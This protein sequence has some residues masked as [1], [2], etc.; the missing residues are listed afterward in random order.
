MPPTYPIYSDEFRQQAVDLLVSS[1]RPLKQVAA[2]L[3]VS[4]NSLRSWRNRALGAGSQ[5]KVEAPLLRGEADAAANG[6]QGEAEIRRLRR[7]NEY[8]RRQRDILKKAM[9]ILGED[10]QLGMR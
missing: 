7:E 10:P 6:P 5:G 2:D 1:G 3:G 8:L 9:S 4:P